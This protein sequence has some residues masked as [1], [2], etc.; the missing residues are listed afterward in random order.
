MT[1][2][3]TIEELYPQIYLVII[4]NEYDLALTFCR[5]QE[6][7]ESPFPTIR[8]KEFTL[9]E[10]MKVYSEN[11]N[12]SFGIFSYPADW[13][14]FNIPGEVILELYSKRIKDFNIY[15]KT[16]LEITKS[17]KN[18]KEKFYI[19][20]ASKND[21]GGDGIVRHELSH[22]LWGIDKTYKA[23]CL[24][25]LSHIPQETKIK[26][27]EILLSIGYCE[28]TIDDEIN[29]YLSTDAHH[30]TSSKKITE[31][32]K[33]SLRVVISILRGYLASYLNSG[34]KDSLRP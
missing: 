14:G 18:K 2:H 33:E 5:A 25:I 8:G 9:L 17:I 16:I 7:Y 20:G 29:A 26:L 32:E 12:G 1:I 3:Y 24:D 19:I 21:I 13:S 30:F 11:S 22:G 15:D 28:E 27:K 31:Q 6:Y 34:I 4:P 23:T 10:F